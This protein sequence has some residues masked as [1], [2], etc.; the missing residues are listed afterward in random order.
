[1]EMGDAESKERGP[2]GLQA[3]V[4]STSIS[5]AIITIA[6]KCTLLQNGNNNG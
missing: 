2:C 3:T 6:S 5:A 4:L 1:M